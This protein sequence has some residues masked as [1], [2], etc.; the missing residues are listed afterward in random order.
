MSVCLARMMPRWS[1]PFQLHIRAGIATGPWSSRPSAG[2]IAMDGHASLEIRR[3]D[4]PGS[5]LNCAACNAHTPPMSGVPLVDAGP[6]LIEREQESAV[7]DGLVDSLRDGGRAGPVR[8]QARIGKSAP[9]PRERRPSEA[10]A[11][12]TLH[13]RVVESA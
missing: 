8:G 11:V 3:V 10:P 2:E 12:P 13:T 9:L 7:L 5:E 1:H 4:S 6:D